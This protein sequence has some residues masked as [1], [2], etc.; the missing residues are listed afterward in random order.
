M[1]WLAEDCR[2]AGEGR[3]AAGIGVVAA[4]RL[5][6]NEAPLLCLEPRNG[7]GVAGVLGIKP[8]KT[9]QGARGVAEVEVDRK[10]G[11]DQGEG[12]DGRK[13]LFLFPAIRSARPVPAIRSPSISSTPVPRRIQATE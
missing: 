4:D 13:G 8:G 11:D 1:E 6:E 2:D 9:V 3:D 7:G 12:G 5:D 10:G